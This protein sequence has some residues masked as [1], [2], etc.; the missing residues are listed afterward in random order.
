MKLVSLEFNSVKHGN[1][2]VRHLSSG[3]EVA[4]SG[5]RPIMTNT[6]ASNLLAEIFVLEDPDIKPED[7]NSSMTNA[8]RKRMSDQIY[9]MIR[10]M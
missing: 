1:I 7:I 5:N 8:F 10:L 6:N 9:N 3:V 4:I 2:Y